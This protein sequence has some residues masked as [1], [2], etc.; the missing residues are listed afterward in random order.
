MLYLKKIK[1]KACVIFSDKIDMLSDN[2]LNKAPKRR[3]RV[4]GPFFN[5]FQGRYKLGNCHKYGILQFYL[6]KYIFF[7]AYST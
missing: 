2:I 5:W 6:S 7:V 3:I 4:Q 1:F